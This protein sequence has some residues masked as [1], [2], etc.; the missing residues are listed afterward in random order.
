M[1]SLWAFFTIYDSISWGVM[2]SILFIQILFYISFQYFDDYYKEMNFRTV[3]NAIFEAVQL[4]LGQTMLMRKSYAQKFNIVVTHFL[5]Y[6]ILLGVY[7]SWLFSQKITHNKL[8]RIEGYP[9]LIRNLEQSRRYF[10]TTTGQDWFFEKLHHSRGYP[11]NSMRSTLKYN[12]IVVTGSKKK[13]LDLAANDDGLVVVMDDD[14]SA[15]M[16]RSYCGLTKMGEPI[17]VHSSRLIICQR[18]RLLFQPPI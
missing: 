9:E 5:H 1:D 8:T 18:F 15:F 16:A 14:E 2:A 13:T 3:T 17:S 7:S 4:Q 10:V 11:Y 12:P 6:V